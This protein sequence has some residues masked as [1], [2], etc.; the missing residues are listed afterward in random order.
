MYA[1]SADT[2]LGDVQAKAAST[3][4]M[5]LCLPDIVQHW[6]DCIP[7]AFQSPFES[8]TLHLS[9]PMV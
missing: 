8:P 9:R 5:V 1:F 7:S 4:G 3:A 2:S 6:G